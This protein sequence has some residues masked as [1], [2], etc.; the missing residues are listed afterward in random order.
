M[1]KQKIRAHKK[2]KYLYACLLILGLACR[3]VLITPF[4]ASAGGFAVYTHGARELARGNSVVA[5]PEGPTSSYFNPATLP[6]L[7]GNQVE[8]GVVL[9]A[10][11]K[12]FTGSTSGL[13]TES[14]SNLSTPFTLFSAW[15][16]N[17]RFTAGLGINNPFGL[18]NEWPSNWEGRY[19]S[20][21]GEMQSFLVNP[22]MAWRV[23][24]RFTIAAGVDFLTADITLENK[25]PLGLTDGN[26]EFDADGDAWGF[27]LGLLY[28]ITERISFGISYRS[29]FDLEVKGDIE[30][31][32]Q[33]PPILNNTTGHGEL[34]LPAQAFAG[35]AFQVTDSF[36]FELGCRWEEW[37][38]YRDLTLFFD[39]PVAGITMQSVPKNWGDNYAF[40]A[41]GKFTMGEGLDLLFG[42]LYDGTPVPDDTFEPSV[43]DAEKHL[44]SLGISKCFGDFTGS[45]TYAYQ[46]YKERDKNNT[47]ATANGS[48][49][50]QTHMA[51]ISLAYSF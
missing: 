6:E 46:H 2:Y 38:R 18:G 15:H 25:F 40:N 48:Y 49:S 3:V 22:S 33:V 45:L 28:K 50:Q 8:T 12:E 19:L 39:T 42:Y 34:N 37:S 1:E 4:Y 29:A 43:S 21:E 14:E 10:P 35:L 36:V 51:A 23:T 30:F 9:I 32:P 17:D 47:I 5:S 44:L 24:D 7:K 26:R 11:S 27:N 16:I 41:G 20:T 31:T 13:T